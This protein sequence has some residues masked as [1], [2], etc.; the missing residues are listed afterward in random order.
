MEKLKAISML[1]SFLRGNASEK[2]CEIISQKSIGQVGVSEE[3]N[4]SSVI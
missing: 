2:I 1:E 3:L 4:D